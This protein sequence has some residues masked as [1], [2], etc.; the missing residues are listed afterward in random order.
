M[1]YAIRNT[2]ILLVTLFLIVGLGLGYNNFFQESL[3]EDLQLEITSKQQDLNSKQNINNEFSELND[4]YQ[5]AL[6]IISNYDKMLFTSNK[7]DDVYDFMNEIN[8]DGGSRLFFDFVY[9]DSIPNNQYGVIRSNIS[10]YSD[11][12]ALVS[13]INKIENSQLLNKVSNVT[14]SPGRSE[15]G[16]N[17]VNFAFNLESYYQKT[18]LF[19]SL[20]TDYRIVENNE[21]SSFNPFYPLIQNSIPPNSDGLVNAEASRIVGI[22]GNRIFVIG[23]DG[24]IISLKVGD[25][26]YLGYLSAIDLNNKTATFNLNKGGIEEVV[27]LEVVR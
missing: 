19:D 23:Q 3:I 11:Y 18:Q 26:V 27:T 25:R 12:D 24:K 6:G 14:I 15:D 20:S 5:S 4:R 16:L 22:A 10:G 8:K 21:I 7:P 1:S 13:F 2:I 17:S 9:S